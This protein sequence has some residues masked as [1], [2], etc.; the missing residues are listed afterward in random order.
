MSHPAQGSRVPISDGH[1]KTRMYDAYQYYLTPINQCTNLCELCTSESNPGPLA[2]VANVQSLSYNNRTTHQHAF[3]IL[4]TYYTGGTEMPQLY[5]WQLLRNSLHIVGF[6]WLIPGAAQCATM[7]LRHSISCI[8]P[9][10]QRE[11]WWLLV[12][13]LSFSLVA[14]HCCLRSG[15]LSLSH[16]KC[17][18]I[19]S[20]LY[21]FLPSGFLNCIIVLW[22]VLG[23]WSIASSYTCMLGT[24]CSMPHMAAKEA[25]GKYFSLMPMV[26]ILYTPSETFIDNV[27]SHCDVS[28]LWNLSS[29]KLDN[30]FL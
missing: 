1:T 16:G 20:F 27:L 19:L 10:M 25:K 23:L 13:W 5:I 28:D 21:F 18:L 24:V 9:P 26:F 8:V 11:L 6:W 15:I 7:Q 3:T 29:K 12:V 2:W 30:T 22:R 14:E 4:Y 17:S